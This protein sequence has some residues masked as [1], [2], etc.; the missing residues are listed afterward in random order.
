MARVRKPPK[1]VIMDAVSGEYRKFQFNPTP[2]ATEVGVE[3]VDI[4]S[5]GL[6]HP[7]FQYVGGEADNITFTIFL[8]DKGEFRG[9][10]DIFLRFLERFRATDNSQFNPPPPVTIAYGAKVRTGLIQSMD[11][12]ET[13]FDPINLMVVRAEIEIKMVSLPV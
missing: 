9:Y 13:R 12:E 4:R 8:D 2:M 3:Y 10:T 1:A 5:P 7:F 6:A 11:I